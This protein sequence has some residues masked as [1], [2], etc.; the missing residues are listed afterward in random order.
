MTSLEQRTEILALIDEARAQGARLAPA[1]E[2]IGI[3]PVTVRR[4]R[5]CDSDAIEADGRPEAE[6]AEPSNRLSEAERDQIVETC[7]QREYAS[8]SPGQIV[9]RLADSG[10]Y[11][12][13][14]STFYRVLRER[15]QLNHRGRQRAPRPSSPPT[16]HIATESKQVWMLDVT[17]LPKGIGYPA[18][19][20][21]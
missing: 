4:W 12:A 16:T 17:W 11:L 7:N 10:V 9:P 19:M 6:R 21:H 8:S 3:D 13:S 14:E 15:G 20:Y 5:P 2:I 1:C 18:N